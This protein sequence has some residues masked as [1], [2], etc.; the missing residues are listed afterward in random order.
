VKLI[1][2]RE[3]L[4]DFVVLLKRY[5]IA[6]RMSVEFHA[7]GGQAR[8]SNPAVA[9]WMLE[10]EVR[11]QLATGEFRV[12]FGWPDAVEEALDSL[13]SGRL[14]YHPATYA[15]PGK[16]KRE[17]ASVFNV[18]R[19]EAG[20]SDLQ[21][22]IEHLE[23]AVRDG[24]GMTSG[25]AS[26]VER[27]SD[28]QIIE[29]LRAVGHRLTTTELID[30]MAQRGLNPSDSTVK[31]RLAAMVKNGQLT[32]DPKAKPRGYGLPEWRDGSSGSAGS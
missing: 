13:R 20:L 12:P 3:A 31:K 30:E 18:G 6:C 19:A 24:T 27:E 4:D 28:R 5:L 7:S 17:V 14:Y 32:N 2:S 23:A 22:L 8:S 25:P 1:P 11:E 9:W 15:T 26:P 21:R 10:R 16:D 29:T